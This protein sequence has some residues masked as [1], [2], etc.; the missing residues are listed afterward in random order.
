M[1]KLEPTLRNRCDKWLRVSI[2]Y[3]ILHTYFIWHTA[4]LSPIVN[5]AICKMNPFNK[6]FKQQHFINT[7]L[8]KCC[9]KQKCNTVHIQ[10]Q[11]KHVC[12]MNQLN[13]GNVRNKVE[14]IFKRLSIWFNGSVVS[15]NHGMKK[16]HGT[17]SLG[18]RLRLWALEVEST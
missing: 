3:S 5:T 2:T 13:K 7:L 1:M 11:M 9:P 18:S 16:T 15:M 14:L 10:F 12:T 6:N 4:L 17:F 8:I